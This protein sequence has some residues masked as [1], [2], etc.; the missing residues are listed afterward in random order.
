MRS[1]QV[2]KWK[3]GVRRPA[4]GLKLRCLLLHVAASNL[5]CLALPC[6]ALRRPTLPFYPAGAWSCG[7]PTPPSASS[8]TPR[9]Q[10]CLWTTAATAPRACCASAQRST[11]ECWRQQRG[12]TVGVSPVSCERQAHPHTGI[13][14]TRAAGSQAGY[15]AGPASLTH[16]AAGMRHALRLAGH[17]PVP[18]L[19]LY[20]GCAAAEPIVAASS[21]GAGL[22]FSPSMR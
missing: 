5:P 3:R 16:A 4:D 11:S 6:L 13:H 20:R 18:R 2:L 22:E 19:F 17:P 10:G 15:R 21:N 14:G 8:P 9:S 12:S 7:A 1:A